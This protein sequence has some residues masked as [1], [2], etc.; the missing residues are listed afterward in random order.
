MP[1]LKV[2]KMVFP[3]HMNTVQLDFMACDGSKQ[4]NSTYSPINQEGRAPIST[5]KESS[6]QEVTEQLQSLSS[7]LFLLSRQKLS[8]IFFCWFCSFSNLFFVLLFSKTGPNST[9]L[10]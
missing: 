9:Q 2:Y 8:Y 1:V 7:P 3:Q 6:G 5:Q 4:L 10:C